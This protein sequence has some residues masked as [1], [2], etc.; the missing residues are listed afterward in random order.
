MAEKEKPKVPK[1][2][3]FSDECLNTDGLET[4]FLVMRVANFHRKEEK[5][6]KKAQACEGIFS[7]SRS[8]FASK[9][10]LMCPGVS[11]IEVLKHNPDPDDIRR[12]VIVEFDFSQ[13]ERPGRD[14]WV[15]GGVIHL[16]DCQ[17]YGI[18][19]TEPENL[20]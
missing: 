8:R 17:W 19:K 10:K 12:Y 16:A 13:K 9:L 14:T 11:L 7:N 6:A 15:E 18:K 4:L 1:F 20:D 2:G 5:N 3:P